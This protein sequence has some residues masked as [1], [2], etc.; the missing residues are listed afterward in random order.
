MKEEEK[1]QQHKKKKGKIYSKTRNN[2]LIITALA[3]NKITNIP[4][5]AKTYYNT[6]FI[7]EK[8]NRKTQQTK[9]LHNRFKI[10][11]MSL[12]SSVKLINKRTKGR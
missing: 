10:R 1:E 6:R 7:R 3:K 4:K 12:L 5:L 9:E 8:R 2:A 11:H